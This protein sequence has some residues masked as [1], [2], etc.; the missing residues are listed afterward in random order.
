MY[1]ITKLTII[2]HHHTNTYNIKIFFFIIRSVNL[3]ME[4]LIPNNLN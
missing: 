1:D 3:Y 2:L 4:N